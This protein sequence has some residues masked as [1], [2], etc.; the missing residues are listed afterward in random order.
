MIEIRVFYATWTSFHH[1]QHTY[2]FTIHEK[3]SRMTLINVHKLPGKQFLTSQVAVS[4]HPFET[5]QVKVQKVK[6]GTQVNI[7]DMFWLN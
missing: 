1:H 4:C 7:A 3:K 5:R 6:D 2:E